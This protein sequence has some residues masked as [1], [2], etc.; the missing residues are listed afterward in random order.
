MIDIASRRRE[1][2]EPSSGSRSSAAGREQHREGVAAEQV[3]HDDALHAAGDG[4]PGTGRSGRGV[5]A[6]VQE[7]PDGEQLRGGERAGAAGDI[8]QWIISRSIKLNPFY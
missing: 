5:E 3:P 7:G 8:K 4:V 2:R 1:S 6:G